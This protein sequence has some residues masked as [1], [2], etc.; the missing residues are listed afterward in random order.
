MSSPIRFAALLLLSGLASAGLH[1]VPTDP[2]WGKAAD[3]KILA[4]ALVN[5]VLAHHPELIILGIH[6]VA[7]GAKDEALI[8]CNLDRIGKKDD[9]DD[10]A[11]ATEGKMILAPNLKESSK[12]EV[13]LPLLDAQGKVVGSTGFVFHYHA[14]QD[15]VQLLQRALSIRAALARKIADH[16][17][18]FQPS[19]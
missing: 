7:P 8:A 3:N 13:Q 17:A 18:L 5:D 10:I 4:Q 2:S 6:S 12:F 15:V 19:P 14:G 16:D 11:V 1:A 9:D